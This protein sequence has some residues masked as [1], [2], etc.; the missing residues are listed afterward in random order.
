MRQFEQIKICFQGGHTLY[1]QFHVTIYIF[2]KRIIIP[3]QGMHFIQGGEGERR[4]HT[5]GV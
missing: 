1:I 4:G 5:D 2:W 3:Y